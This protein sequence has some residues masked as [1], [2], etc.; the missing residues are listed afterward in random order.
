MSGTLELLDIAGDVALL[1]WATG[2]MASSFAAS[3]F[4]DLASGLVV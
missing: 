1:L 3:G 4:L 2:L